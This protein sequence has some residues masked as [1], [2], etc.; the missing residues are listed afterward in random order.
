MLNQNK[1]NGQKIGAMYGQRQAVKKVAT[2]AS[3]QDQRVIRPKKGVSDKDGSSANK[4]LDLAIKG[5]L[6]LTMLL[7]PLFFLANTPSAL[8]LG[9]QVLLVGLIGLAFLF[10]VGR[11]AIKSRINFRANFLFIPIFVLLIIIGL[12]AFLGDYRVQSMWGFFGGEARSYVSLVFFI[13]FFV[14]LV[15][16]IKTQRDIV[17]TLIVLLAGG[18]LTILLG[19]LQLWGK[20]ILPINGTHN[21]FFNTVGSVYLFGIYSSALFLLA[22]NMLVYSQK[23]IWKVVLGI[24]SVFFFIVLAVINVKIIWIALV[25]SLA[26]VFGKLIIGGEKKESSFSSVVLMVFLVLSLLMILRGQPIIKKQLPVE[27][28]LTH[29]TSA[30]IAWKAVKH[31]FLL[32]SG[33]ANY[34]NIYRA[35]RPSNLGNF[36]ATNF[37]TASSYFLTLVSTVGVLGTLAFLFLIISG[38]IYLFRGLFSMDDR[39]SSL[40]IGVGSTWILLT[41]LLLFYV[42]NMTTLFMW[43]VMLALLVVILAFSPRTKLREFSTGSASSKPSLLFSFVFVLVI[44]GVVVALYLQGQKYMAAV[45]FNKALVA[46]AKGDDIQKVVNEINNAVLMDADRDLYYRNRSLA[47]FAIANKKISDRGKDFNAEDAAFVSNNIK[48]ALADA[49]RADELNANDVDNKIAV[50]NV[51]E[52][53]LP[54]MEGAG[55]KA[56]EYAKKAAELDPNN[57]AVYQRLVNIYI[58]MADLETAKAQ[59]KKEK[60]LPD[61]AKEYLVSAKD[62]LNKA[63]ELKPDFLPARLALVGIFD[64]EGENDKAIEAMIDARKASPANPNL[65]FQLGLLYLRQDKLDEAG[66]QFVQAIQIDKNYANAHYFL[67]LVLDKKDRK[68]LAIKE[69]EKV[70]ELNKGNKL[71]QKIIENLKANK[72]ALAGLQQSKEIK[73]ETKKEDKK[74]E[75]QPSI[76]PNVEEQVIP[77]EA[78]PT[79]DEQNQADQNSA[80]SNPD[81]N[82]SDTGNTDNGNTQ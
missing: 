59:A 30:N 76:N 10:W 57:P 64:R 56:L 75:P 17:K 82:N 19:T 45:H 42:A 52:S 22:L 7:L 21:Q 36:W 79:I 1:T 63:I 25:V 41:I 69:F 26:L 46:D 11:M 58:S 27:V 35:Y 44:I 62:N 55:D 24:L 50:V 71:V 33:P 43:W 31:D 73:N 70:L 53:L 65:A 74:N 80:Q 2:T 16:N 13:A 20:F 3:S 14:L 78:T 61:K 39:L 60:G 81:N 34:I 9:K 6:W 8:E 15:N 54:T 38:L 66:A 12:S 5:L 29:K 32:G 72:D 48:Q 4:Y 28:L 49:S 67:G 51:Y 40:G 18:F 68:D 47:F 23:F 37:N 77:K